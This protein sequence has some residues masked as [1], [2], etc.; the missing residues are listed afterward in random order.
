LS[1][2]SPP[3]SSMT[4]KGMHQLIDTK[5]GTWDRWLRLESSFLMDTTIC[6]NDTTCRWRYH[7][8]NTTCIKDLVTLIPKDVDLS[9]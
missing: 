1:T 8:T 2:I 3:L 9:P 6:W 4:I 5:G 7:M